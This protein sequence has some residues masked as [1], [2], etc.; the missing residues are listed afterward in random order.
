M[1]WTLTEFFASGGATR[2]V[3]RL[4]SVL[5]LHSSQIKMVS[6]YEGSLVLDYN[7]LPATQSTDDEDEDVDPVALAEVAL[8]AA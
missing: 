6:V 1:K 4:A 5:G 8:I 7:I 2:F 3:D